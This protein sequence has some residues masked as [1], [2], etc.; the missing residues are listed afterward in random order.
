VS[1]LRPPVIAGLTG[2]AGTSTLA[3]ALHASDAG[4]VDG[5]ADVLVCRST[6]APL[7]EAA[8]VA[9]APPGGQQPV[10]AVTL[11]AAAPERGAM[12]ARLRALESRFHAVVV[13]PHVGRWHDL[14]DSRVEAATVL[15]QPVEHLARPLRAYAAALRHL[16]AAVV[17]SGQLDR[18][19]PPPV[20]R[21]RAVELWRGLRPVER[22]VP[23]RPILLARPAPAVL[24]PVAGRRRPD[25]PC[26]AP[27]R[28][29]PHDPEPD[30]ETLE[31]DPAQATAAAGRAG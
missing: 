10:L 3:A 22:S 17:G 16:V 13:L 24:L 7:Q 4:R 14:A 18:P 19:V 6:E 1:P 29:R 25:Q 21:P 12:A 9:C 30:D 20:T 26:G 31:A 11:L 8:A 28:L 27:P 5:A 2:D 15:A 23:L